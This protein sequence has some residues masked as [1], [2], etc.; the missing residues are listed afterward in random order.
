[1]HTERVLYDSFKKILVLYEQ[2]YVMWQ[3]Y[4]SNVPTNGSTSKTKF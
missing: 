2:I 1:M 4:T 3:K